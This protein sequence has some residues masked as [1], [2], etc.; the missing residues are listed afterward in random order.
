[1]WH[2]VF[3]W[4]VPAGTRQHSGLIFKVWNA[5]F[6]LTFRPL[7]VRTLACFIPLGTNHAMMCC[8]IPEG[9]QLQLH[10]CESLKICKR[11]TDWWIFWNIICCKYFTYDVWSCLLW[12]LETPHCCQIL[13]W[14][15]GKAV[16]LQAW[17]G[18]EGSRR[19]RFPD[20]KTVGTWK[21]VGLSALCTGC[22]YTLEIFLVLI[23]VRGWVNPRAIVRPEGL[24]QWKIP[25]TP[26]GIEPSD[27][28]TCSA[29]PQPTVL[30]R[31]PLI[32]G[33]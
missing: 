10:Y 6:T 3:E 17:T 24:C 31:A 27:L 33:T 9:Q 23:Y 13:I 32:W 19:L 15:K 2:H 22:L 25:M 18:P 12:N 16:P 29:V 20:F 28:P 26:S 1:M 21:V 4:L 7:N 30:P 5:H 11:Y 14:G 8:H